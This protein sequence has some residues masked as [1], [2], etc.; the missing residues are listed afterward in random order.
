MVPAFTELTGCCQIGIGKRMTT[1]NAQLNCAD[2]CY[3]EYCVSQYHV[4]E[5]SI[6]VTQRGQG[7]FL[8]EGSTEFKSEDILKLG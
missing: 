4:V 5:A 3:K 7:L 1:R 6:L 2:S 8:R